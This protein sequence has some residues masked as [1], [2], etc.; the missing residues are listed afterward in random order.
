MLVLQSRTD[1]LQLLPG[2][3]NETLTTSSAVACNF[4][5]IEVEDMFVMGEGFIAIKE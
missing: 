2:S 4:S 1:S 3:S 5:N